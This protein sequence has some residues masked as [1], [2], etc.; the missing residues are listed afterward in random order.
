MGT[1]GRIHGSTLRA[2]PLEGKAVAARAVEHS[3]L[4][5]LAS[6][7]LRVPIAGEYPMAEAEAAY[8]RFATGGK[9]G[10]IVLVR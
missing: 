7:A 2:R 10:K 5:A 8:E 4:P 9:L 1:R 6:G 3:V